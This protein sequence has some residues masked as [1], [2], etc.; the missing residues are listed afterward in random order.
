[1]QLLQNNLF[2]RL[3]TDI[4]RITAVMNVETEIIRIIMTSLKGR[5]VIFVIV[6][7]ETLKSHIIVLISNVI[8]FQLILKISL[9]EIKGDI[10]TSIISY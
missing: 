6:Y 5:A 9:N 8:M 4:N 10:M 3:V 2:I 1:M 7:V